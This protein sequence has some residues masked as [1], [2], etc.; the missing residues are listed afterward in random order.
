MENILC[1]EE[2]W[3]PVV[4]YENLYEVSNLGRVRTIPKK[5]FNKQVTRKTG[6]DVR[7]GYTTIMLRKNNVLRTKRIHSLVVEAFLGI[8]T[9]KKLVANHINGNKRDNRLENLELISQK[10]NIHH[11]FNLGLVT[12]T[13][14]DARYN[15]KIKEKD[16]PRLLEMF[17]TDMTSKEI[18]KLFN[19]NPTT[20]SRIRKG[21]RRPYLTNDDIC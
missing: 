5:G 7:T 2:V 13:T 20:I 3:K 4:G 16:F 1:A 6:L 15:S 21:K 12:I 17:K 18:A 14:G 11:A 9:N 19:V 8:K 10:E